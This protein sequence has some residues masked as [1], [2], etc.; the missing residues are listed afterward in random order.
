MHARE[1]VNLNELENVC[2]LNA[3]EVKFLSEYGCKKR[4]AR[5]LAF[6]DDY[7]MIGCIAPRGN[8][9]LDIYTQARKLWR[10]LW[11]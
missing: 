9:P 6:S 5:H 10:K 3:A 1:H 7:H 8:V 11:C 2:P 4:V